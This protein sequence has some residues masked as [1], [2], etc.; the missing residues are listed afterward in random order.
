MRCTVNCTHYEGDGVTVLRRNELR[1][2]H[3]MMPVMARQLSPVPIIAAQQKGGA[4][5]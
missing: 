5:R 4:C 3:D 1:W 2:E